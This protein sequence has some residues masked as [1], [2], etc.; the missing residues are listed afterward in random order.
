M[1]PFLVSV[2]SIVLGEADDSKGD[3]ISLAAID[4][5]RKALAQKSVSSFWSLNQG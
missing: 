1:E 3:C 2:S 4:C 5:W